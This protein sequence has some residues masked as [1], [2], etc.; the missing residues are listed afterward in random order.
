MP[1][2]RLQSALRAWR[3]TIRGIRANAQGISEQTLHKARQMLAA[4]QSP[5]EVAEF[6]A[7]TLTNRIIHAP[8]HRLRIAGEEGDEALIR[9]AR[10]LFDLGKE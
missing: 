10:E 2:P 4:G 6:L 8:T 3:L 9:A 7:K 5:E 1:A